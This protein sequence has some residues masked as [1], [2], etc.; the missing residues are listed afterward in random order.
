MVRI[1]KAP[2]AGDYGESDMRFEG[3]FVKTDH[4]MCPEAYV[5]FL[6]TTYY[7]SSDPGAFEFDATPGSG[8]GSFDYIVCNIS[9]WFNLVLLSIMVCG[10]CCAGA[11]LGAAT[12][13]KQMH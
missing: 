13:S 6:N 12:R 9:A 1:V 8:A 7:T 5:M 2:A 10:V 11:A 3:Q 4:F